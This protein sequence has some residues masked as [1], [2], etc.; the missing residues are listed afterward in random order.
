M[1]DLEVLV[2]KL[3]TIDGFASCAITPGKVTALDHEI[4]DDAMEGG[5]FVAEPLLTSC[6]GAE[7]L[8]RL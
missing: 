7:V 8:N 1:L 4:F 5:A 3:V 6:Q 2:V